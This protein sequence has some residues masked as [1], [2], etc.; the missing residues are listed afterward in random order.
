MPEPFNETTWRARIR[1]FWREAARDLPGTMQRLGV[2][3]AYG[4][5]TASAWLPLLAACGDA[6]GPAVA[7]L[8]GVLS[9]VGTNLLSNLVQRACDK[10]TISQ[11]EQEIA[12][13]P[14]LRAGYE[15][16]LNRLEV[17]AA[18]REAL[19][20]RWADFEARLREE[21]AQLG[22]CLQV[23]TGGG[24]V[25]FGDVRVLHGDFV[26]RDKITVTG[27]GSRIIIAPEE[28][29]PEA[30]LAAYLRTLARDCQR[31]PLGVVDPRF[32]QGG[33][34]TPV[35]LSKGHPAP[36]AMPSISSTYWG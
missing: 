14:E 13:Q 17:L 2:R 1:D 8:V 28:V 21:L 34:E 26:G 9:G 6:P 33:P 15:Q 12:E 27:D 16:I 25:V 10:A 24:A 19:G 30:L 36:S 18:A 11:V 20:E 22:G 29:S 7:A 35:S 32:L 4:L 23:E 3:T 5:L 31:L